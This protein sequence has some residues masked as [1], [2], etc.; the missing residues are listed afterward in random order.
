[1]RCTL[2]FPQTNVD[3]GCEGRRNG[4][5]VRARALRA[6]CR[7]S[8]SYN[9]AWSIANIIRLWYVGSSK[10][11]SCGGQHDGWKEK[12]FW[13]GVNAVPVKVIHKKYDWQRYKVGR[14]LYSGILTEIWTSKSSNSINMDGTFIMRRQTSTQLHGKMKIKKSSTGIS[15]EWCT[16]A[17]TGCK[18]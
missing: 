6:R 4:R 5:R 16:Y 2:N 3:G 7:R 1:M 14:V 9:G 8:A 10:E 17:E 12:I 18:S 15:Y 13:R 11:R